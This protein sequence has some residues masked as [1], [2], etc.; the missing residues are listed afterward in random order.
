MLYMPFAIIKTGGKQYIVKPG[1]KIKVEK[2]NSSKDQDV[3]FDNVLLIGGEKS[4][5]ILVGA[6]F[7]TDYIVKGKVLS[8]GKRE[9]IIVY[10]F[11]SKKHYQRKQGHRQLYTEVEILAISQES[12]K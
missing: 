3:V 1:D 11:K 4:E 10:K 5:E 12:A 9:K 7:L 6:P 8:E 2:L